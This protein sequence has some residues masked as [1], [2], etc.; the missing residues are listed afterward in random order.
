MLV[1]KFL[2]ARRAVSYLVGTSKTMSLN[3]VCI[4][5]AMGD[6]DQARGDSSSTLSYR[7]MLPLETAGSIAQ[8]SSNGVASTTR[9]LDK[10]PLMPGANFHISLRDVYFNC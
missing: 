2:T 4:F 6:R 3:V 5:R 1:R 8:A 9:K 7:G 10:T